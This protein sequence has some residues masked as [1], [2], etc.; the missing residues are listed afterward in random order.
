MG[1]CGGG[2]VLG[3]GVARVQVV[4]EAGAGEPDLPGH[5]ALRP[6]G[7]LLFVAPEPGDAH[8]RVWRVG[9]TQPGPEIRLPHMRGRRPQI[10][11]A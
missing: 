11:A 3:G 10:R 4:R 6:R 1:R 2:V 7:A 8:V 9:D 5:R